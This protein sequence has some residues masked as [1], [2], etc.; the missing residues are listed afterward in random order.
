MRTLWSSLGPSSAMPPA[1][2]LTTPA[3]LALA[4]LV[5]ASVLAAS[6]ALRAT[7]YDVVIDEIHYHPLSGL[8]ED[9]F[10]ELHN[11]GPAAVDLSGWALDEGIHLRFPPGTV[12][13]PKAFLVVSPDAARLWARGVPNA[14]GDYTGR[15]DNDGEVVTLVNAAGEIRSRVHYGVSGAW[16]SAPDGLGPSL[17][18]V[19]PHAQ[20]DSPRSWAASHAIGGTPG[21]ESSAG[22]SIDLPPPPPPAPGVQRA[23]HART[24]LTINEVRPSGPGVPGWIEIFNASEDPVS[25]GGAGA[26]GPGFTGVGIADSRG[27]RFVRAGPLDV[28]ARG[29]RA[30]GAAVLGFPPDLEG[31]TYALFGV[32][33]ELG[34]VSLDALETR[35]P[36]AGAAPPGGP[37]AAGAA[38]SF[39][40]FPDGG[41]DTYLLAE[42]SPEAPNGL[43]VDSRIVINEI[44]FHPPFVEPSDGCDRNCSDDDQWIELHNRSAEPADVGGWS[45]TKGVDLLIPAP[46]AIPAGGYLVIAASRSTFLARYPGFDPDLVV[47]DWKRHLAR[48]SDTIN[49]RDALGNRV[50]HVQYGDGKPID[51]V[52]PADGVN[53]GTF[54]GT[55]WPWDAD[56]TGRTLELIHP[57]LD[58]R[59]GGAWRAGPIGGTPG[60]RNAS[61]DPAPPPVIDRVAHSP[62]VPLPGEEVVVSCRLSGTGAIESVQLDWHVEN[63]AGSGSVQL[64][65]GGTG[66]D[67]AAGDGTY[68]GAIPPRPDGAVVAFTVTARIAGGAETTVPSPPPS[69]PYA[70]F[71]GPYFLYQVLAA[72]PPDNPSD[73]CYVIMAEADRAH[74]AA[75]SA[76]SDALLPCTFIQVDRDGSSEV[77]HLAGI[78]YR[79]AALRNQAR[80]SYRIDFPSEA[81]LCGVMH[82][83]LNAIGVDRELLVSD[84]FRRAGMPYPRGWSVNLHFQGTLD[85]R[86]VAKEHLDVDFLYRFFGPASATG[87]LYRAI[88]PDGDPRAGDLVYHGEDPQDYVPYY[89]KRTNKEEGDWSDIIELART[90]DPTETPDAVFLE[91]L[92]AIAD[93]RQWARYLA[94]Q[95]L[96]SNPDGSLHTSSGED[97]FL[98]KVPAA[99]RRADRGKWVLIPWDIDEAF[100]SSSASLFPTRL[101]A[102]QRFLRVPELARL[103]KG[104]LFR[105]RD[106][107]FSRFELRQRLVLID[108]LFGFS[109]IDS[110]D[111]FFTNRIGFVD[112][113][114]PRGLSAGARPSDEAG[115]PIVKVGDVWSY[116]KGTA[117]PPGASMAWT[118]LGYDA[119]AWES[120][121]TGIGYADGDDATV[122]DDMRGR[123]TVVFARR[124]FSVAD[125]AALGR[126]LLRVDYDDGFVAF[127][128]GVEVARR[129]VAG[130]AGDPVEEDD[131]ASGGRE[132]GTPETID[133]DAFRSEIVAGPNV[134]AFAV[135]NHV[136]DS[137][138][139]SLIP[140]LLEAGAQRG[141]FGCGTTLW[142]LGDSVDL[143]GSADASRTVAVRVAGAPASF[144][145]LAAAWS[146]SVALP[147][148]APGGIDVTIE[149]ID[150]AGFVFETQTVTILSLPRQPASVSGA[151]E[152][153]TRLTAAGGPYVLEGDLTVPAGSVLLVDPGTLI[154]GR[155][156]ASVIVRGEI[157]ALGT[158]EEPILFRPWSCADRI[159]GIAMDGTGTAAGS[160][161]QHLRSCDFQYAGAPSGYAGCVAP[162]RS[163]LRAEGCSFRNIA[164]NVIDGTNARVEVLGCLFER[165]AEGVHCTRSTVTIL[166]STFRGMVGDKDA[167]DFDY[168]GTERS[169]IERCLIEDGSD[170]GIDLQEAT[171]DIR[172]NVIRNVA[173]KALSLETDGPL[174][175]STIT[176]NLIYG[177]GTAVALKSGIRID[178][179]SH[180]TIVGNQQG[181]SLWAKAGA[182]DGGHAII[183]SSIVWNNIVDVKLDALSSVRFAY[184]NVRGGVRGSVPDGEGNISSDPRFAHVGTDAG[185]WDLSLRPDSPCIG[186][187]KGGSD[188]GALSFSDTQAEFVRGDA[189]GDGMLSVTDVVATLGFI[190]RGDPSPSCPDAHDANDDGEV[191]IVDPVFALVHLFRG[192]SPPPL[193]YPAPGRDPT[194]DGLECR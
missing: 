99:S 57:G 118:G 182:S 31:T 86:Y 55:S 148:P 125:P 45:L 116:W 93:V 192:G 180:N 113:T 62:A 80:K 165:I 96:I 100:S 156:G 77:R 39:G 190:F 191:D 143:Q 24:P 108:F 56:R 69:S 23:T 131:V 128:N 115:A 37:P 28:P 167:I 134:L 84:L 177:S 88:D 152:G 147:E 35:T 104:E 140:E 53:D 188:M 149:A 139:L 123:Y 52:A 187:G 26:G 90:F 150:A 49:L 97:Y 76:R 138:D 122:L 70:G 54:L 137:S 92:D 181:V 72:R 9:E 8:V 119:S 189:S 59:Q 168:D 146:S 184:S 103:A 25:I 18:L 34:D 44:H 159:G 155:G 71:Q 36:P 91:R 166:D 109:Q 135:L 20:P 50:D 63:G 38:E 124:T 43:E 66:P 74:L 94:L 170:D 30:F 61:H 157:R 194:P 173:D 185:A 5:A 158:E 193:P 117:A 178:E 82:L 11:R 120:G 164:S 67:A 41:D 129:N 79:G 27:R 145:P 114:V 2:S 83:N 175:R 162:V 51:D 29:H 169:R 121:P 16:T 75:R 161:V 153:T 85:A 183:E 141:G 22:T 42:A 163:K 21:R 111:T 60:A 19:D 10:L 110:I 160:P 130:S 101:P 102:V 33:P 14:V 1:I 32:D 3:H 154:F 105:L 65:D 107:A 144:D 12:I 58:N 136:L 98:Y 40:R 13:E 132:A 171:V 95:G 151:I 126:L 47:G 127:L 142:A 87:N 7:E 4:A 106:G 15:L 176:G 73:T 112:S 186:T 48:D 68:V 17:E 46:R 172:D 81:R 6:P 179:A 133:V 64:L 174:G 78:R 89:Q